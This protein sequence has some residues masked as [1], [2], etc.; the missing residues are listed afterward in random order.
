M[1]DWVSAPHI[2]GRPQDEHGLGVLEVLVVMV[3]VGIVLGGLTTT[4]VS[5]SRAE[6]D[7]NQR[8]QAQQQ[9][10]LALDRIRGDVHC[11]SAA[12]AQTIGAYPGVKLAVGNCYA[13]T[14]TV[15]WCVVPAASSPPRYQ[16]WRSTASSSICT[17]SDPTRLLVAD[18]L[19]TST[20]VLTTPTIPFQGLETV[21]VDFP[22]SVNPTTG[23]DLYELRDSLVAANSTRCA[24]S[25]GCG[26]PVVP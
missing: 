4:F 19:T 13:S 12:Q 24:S 3:I 9:A 17:S 5:G 18:D 20:N 11:A 1:A 14:P 26:V 16:L 2:T 10:R 21:R 8:F 7:L 6:L 23:H 15:S 25:D 22:V